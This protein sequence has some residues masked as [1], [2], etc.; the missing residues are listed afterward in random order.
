[1]KKLIVVDTETGGLDPSIHSIVSFGA[2]IYQEGSI[3]G[4]FYTLVAEHPHFA[5]IDQIEAGSSAD[6]GAL[7]MP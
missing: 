5:R 3:S 2:V 4:E 7:E 6:I 1:M